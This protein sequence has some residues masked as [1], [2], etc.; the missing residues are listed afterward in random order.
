[1][2]LTITELRQ[3][4]DQLEKCHGHGNVPVYFMDGEYGP[5]PVER[6]VVSTAWFKHSTIIILD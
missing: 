2:P 4:L 5:T 1:M 6:A 3:E